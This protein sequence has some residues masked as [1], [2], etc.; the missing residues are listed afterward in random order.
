MDCHWKWRLITSLI[1]QM[2]LINFCFYTVLGKTYIYIYICLFVYVRIV[3]SFVWNPGRS[4][5]KTA[6]HKPFASYFT[7]NPSMINKTR[8]VLLMNKDEIISDVLPWSPTHGHV[9]PLWPAKSRVLYV[10]Y[11]AYTILSFT[12]NSSFKRIDIVFLFL[13]FHYALIHLDL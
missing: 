12:R 7:S 8:W 3:R 2:G 10:C 4:T 1:I 9:S 6:A 13:F 5:H 11:R